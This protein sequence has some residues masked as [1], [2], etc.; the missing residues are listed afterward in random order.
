MNLN[1]K[2]FRIEFLEKFIPLIKCNRHFILYHDIFISL[3]ESILEGIKIKVVHN[4]YCDFG[5]KKV[6]I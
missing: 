3:A 6:F 5:F 2:S 4:I 1:D